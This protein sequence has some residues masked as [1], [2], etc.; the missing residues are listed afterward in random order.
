MVFDRAGAIK[1]W[2][3]CAAS[4]VSTPEGRATILAPYGMQEIAF[5]Q[6]RDDSACLVTESMDGTIRWTPRGTVFTIETMA[7]IESNLD[8]SPLDIGEGRLVATG[9]HQQFA[10]LMPLLLGKVPDPDELDGHSMGGAVADLMAQT[11]PWKKTPERLIT[12]GKPLHANAVYNR[13]S[14]VPAIRIE[15][16]TDPAPRWDPER[17]DVLEQRP[18][19]WWLHDGITLCDHRP[20]LV[21]FVTGW[22][23]HHAA[24]YGIG[25]S[26]R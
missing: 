19:V 12:L 25:L 15:N 16:E 18:G 24:R 26:A 14:P 9:Y 23:Y 17:D 11:V 6:G 3:T 21:S 13:I 22:T 8:T 1:A 7:S 20:A 4:Y 2:A 10:D 5:V